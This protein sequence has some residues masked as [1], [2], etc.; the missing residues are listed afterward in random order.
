MLAQQR[1]QAIL[2][3]VRGAGGVRVADLVRELS[4]SDMTII[5]VTPSI[6]ATSA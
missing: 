5:I 3:R 6:S 1:Q 4:V 2:E